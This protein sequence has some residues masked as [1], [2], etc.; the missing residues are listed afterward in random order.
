MGPAA[1]ILLCLPS[2][3][4]ARAATPASAPDGSFT[5]VL[6]AGWASGSDGLIRHKRD[7][8][9][10]ELMASRS[11]GGLPAA[12][13]LHGVASNEEAGPVTYTWSG[14]TSDDHA[15]GCIDT[16]KASNAL[17][18]ELRTWCAVDLG[19]QRVALFR[20]ETRDIINARSYG[21]LVRRLVHQVQPSNA[22]AIASTA[23]TA[24]DGTTASASTNTA[25]T[26]SLSTPTSSDLQTRLRRDDSYQCYQGRWNPSAAQDD[27]RVYW[28]AES[29]EMVAR[30]E[31]QDT[32]GVQLYYLGGTVDLANGEWFGHLDR[33][34]GPTSSAS[35]VH[36]MF[37]GVDSQGSAT[38]ST[39]STFRTTQDRDFTRLSVCAGPD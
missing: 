28:R 2:L 20:M 37:N 39:L 14:R 36:R 27:L 11:T 15:A 35:G 8:F 16:R 22:A 23:T 17:K 18:P 32:T 4:Q 38:S 7:A 21:T 34:E 31:V 6:P 3:P 12:D 13:F 10:V 1:L 19:D 9:T 24:T 33:F 26:A 5:L 30:F 25:D 29:N